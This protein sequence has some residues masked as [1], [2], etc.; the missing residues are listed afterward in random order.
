[1]RKFR[2]RVEE[3]VYCGGL[4]AALIKN[5]ETGV[6]ETIYGEPGYMDEIGKALTG[7]LWTSRTRTGLRCC[8]RWLRNEAAHLGAACAASGSRVY[9][10]HGDS[11][12]ELGCPVSGVRLPGVSRVGPDTDRGDRVHPRLRPSRLP[13]NFTPCAC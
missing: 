7:E 1:V 10:P 8:S 12:C 9:H 4:S 13:V 11:V 2:G 3:V 6:V 5:E